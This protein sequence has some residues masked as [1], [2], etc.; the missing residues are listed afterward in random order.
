M[1]KRFCGKSDQGEGSPRGEETELQGRQAGNRNT[2]RASPFEGMAMPRPTWGSHPCME[3]PSK[4]CRTQPSEAADKENAFAA[5]PDERKCSVH[6]LTIRTSPDLM[7]IPLENT[8]KKNNLA[9]YP[10]LAGSHKGTSSSPY[11]F[12]F[13]KERPRTSI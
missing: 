11:V 2:S 4:D 10:P 3:P 7:L 13:K 8:Q 6:T 9:P 1:A 5:L 12:F